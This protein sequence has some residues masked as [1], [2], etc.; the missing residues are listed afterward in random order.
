MNVLITSVGRRTYLVDY[1]RREVQPFGGKVFV[2]NSARHVAGLYVADDYVI[3]PLI[4]SDEYID[5]LCHYI[6]ENNIG[7]IVPAFDCDL[8]CLSLHRKR[9]D[10]LGAFLL[11]GDHE[12]MKMAQDKWLT[13]SFL[14][15]HG[16]N[17]I[18]SFPDMKSF[19]AADARGEVNYPVIVKP[20]FGMGSIGVFEA[21]DA[22]EVQMFYNY[23][24]DIARNSQV[25]TAAGT[26]DDSLV[27][28]QEKIQGDEYGL[29]VIN[30]LQGNYVITVAKR[31]L[32]MRS[33]E[34]DCAEIVVQS[35]WEKMGEKLA[36][37]FRHPG[38]LDVD[39]MIRNGE[40]YILEF[41]PRFGG[42][43]PFSYHAGA[44]L[45]GAI[46][47][48]AKGETIAHEEY[49]S[50]NPGYKAAKSVEIVPI[51]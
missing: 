35:E 4:R 5:F 51:A 18:P 8:E 32:A 48:W 43:F 2:T 17:A 19:T 15:H 26:N 11:A 31:K 46:I 22:G 38:N 13:Q 50:I 44:N 23:V 36:S 40:M 49:F 29:D 12:L 14:E 9:F 3:S 24:Q 37:V 20:R 33:G 39:V 34:T 30:D 42:G 28:I 10:E 6:A 16:F 45:P 1:F 27:I 41:N 21:S 7:L 25:M 47:R